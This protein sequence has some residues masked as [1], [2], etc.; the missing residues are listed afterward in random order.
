MYK[1]K[2]VELEIEKKVA[3]LETRDS[4]R[5]EKDSLVD[6]VVSDHAEDSD[7]AAFGV[8]FVV[9]KL[10]EAYFR[11]L[12]QQEQ[13]GADEQLILPG[14]GHLQR[15]YFMGRNGK[16]EAV[17]VH[18]MT[19]EEFDWKAGQH[20]LMGRGHFDHADEL[21]RFKEGRQAGPA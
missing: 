9:T 19:D 11:N 8:R 16:Q 10:V 20:R 7:F 17:R 4:G 6:A 12:K 2:D 15:R 18:S 21:I 13:N 5:I 14:Y 1:P 3:R